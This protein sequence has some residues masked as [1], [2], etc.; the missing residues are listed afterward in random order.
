M[1]KAREEPCSVVIWLVL[2]S[3]PLTA[4]VGCREKDSQ[5]ES[6]DVKIVE[7]DKFRIA[8]PNE[9]G[10]IKHD[11]HK[12]QVE[13]FR[14]ISQFEEGNEEIVDFI[15]SHPPNLD[16]LKGF[17]GYEVR[18][19]RHSFI[20]HTEV[21]EKKPEDL[22]TYIESQTRHLPTLEDIQVNGVKGKKLGSYSEMGSWIDWWLKEGNC[23]ICLNFQ[24]DGMPSDR[25]KDDVTSILNSL[26]Y[27]PQ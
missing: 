12:E 9:Y 6:R 19:G 4:L 20:F 7:S 10:I 23:M 14:N 16:S 22:A 26:E 27:I 11:V 15:K 2:F 8:I 18:M 3:L 24:G 21:G 13:F 17:Y 1:E 25:I 5:S